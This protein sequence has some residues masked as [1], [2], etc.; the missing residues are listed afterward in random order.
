MRYISYIGA[1][2]S[3]WYATCSASLM[4]LILLQ[5]F[6]Q[7]LQLQDIQQSVEE[8]LQFSTQMLSRS[9]EAIAAIIIAVGIIRA[10]FSYFGAQFFR[11]TRDGQQ[12]MQTETIRLGLGRT[13]GLGLEFLLAADIVSTAVAPTWDAIGKL[14]AIATIRTLLN[15]FLGR[16]LRQDEQRREQAHATVQGGGI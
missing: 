6:L 16:E 7:D 2:L 10:L 13:L 11:A 14:A 9:A 3:R 8:W 4:P 5:P 12:V 15:Y 1:G